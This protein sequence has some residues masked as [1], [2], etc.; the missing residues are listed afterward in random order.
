MTTQLLKLEGRDYVVVPKSDWDRITSG[1]I[2]S[3]ELPPLPEPDVDGSVD[4]VAYARATIARGIIQERR[5]L[6]L[7]QQDLATLSKVRQE[8]IS[9]IET[10]KV[11]PTRRI[12]EKLDAA[13]KRAAKKRAG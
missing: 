9:R 12:V 8:T 2:E 13:M 11:S 7:S 6:G 3:D 10:C 5:R 4:A 1:H